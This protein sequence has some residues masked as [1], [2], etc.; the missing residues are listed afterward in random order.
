MRSLTSGSRTA[1]R[2]PFD[3]SG[4]KTEVRLAVSTGDRIFACTVSL[5]E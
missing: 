4:K 2:V 1:P 5:W 3:G